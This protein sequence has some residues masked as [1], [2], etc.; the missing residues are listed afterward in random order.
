ML[1]RELR[2]D[3]IRCFDSAVLRFTRGGEPCRWVTFLGEN[4]GGKST[5]LQAL[6]LLLAGP[7]GA[8]QLLPRPLGW[9]GDEDRPGK[10]STRVQQGAKDPGTLPKS[11]TAG[12][13]GYGFL[14]TGGKRLSIRNKIFTE[15]T[16]EEADTKRLRWLRAHAFTSTGTGWF[17]AGYGAFR[18]LSRSGQVVVPSLD[19]PAR[20]T[21]FLSQFD[22]DQP[23]AS[24]ERWIVYLDY[25]IAKQKDRH[26]LH[27]RDLGVAA[28]NRLL[29]S[30]ARFDS[31]TPD[32][33]LLFAVH[34]RTV[35]T[36]GLSDGYRSVIALGGDLLWRLLQA[37]PASD[38]SLREEGV[39]LIDELDIHLHPVW[40]RQIAGWLREQFPNLQ[41]IVATHSPLIAA[42]AGDGALTLRF[43][44]EEG[45]AVVRPIENIA[46]MS[47]DRVLQS[48]AFGLLSAYSPQTQA[49]I[50]RYDALQQKD[51]QRT[52][53][54]EAELRS[55]SDF[56]ETARPIGGP[57]PPGSL[58]ARI[59]AYLEKVLK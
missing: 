43:V 4:G 13:I 47:V 29:P 24:F 44:L 5:A 48:E 11:G 23:R 59:E 16:I 22:E 18:R 46:A 38:E 49:K 33:R 40:Q 2:L 12:A 8:R 31:V 28:I 20:Y 55:L 6:G 37:F 52:T 19:P 27:Q 32:G 3:N 42:G 14:L 30:G 39:V 1:V 10:I 15:P 53:Q 7:E 56:M 57:P 51:G 9:L 35:P 25:R 54:E 21:N 17:A 58:D 41:F 36:A 34:G 26:A 45:R 50:D